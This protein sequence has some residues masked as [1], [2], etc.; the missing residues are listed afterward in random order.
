MKRL[1]LGFCVVALTFVAGCN[2]NTSIGGPLPLSTVP[3]TANGGGSPSPK[4]S[5]QITEYATTDTLLGG[6]TIASDGNIYASATTGLDIFSPATGTIHQ[7][8]AVRP[9]TWPVIPNASPTGAVTSFP[10]TVTALGSQ[11]PTATPSMQAAV[12]TQSSNAATPFIATYAIVTKTFTE[13]YGAPGDLFEDVTQTADGSTWVTADRPT[14]N[15]FTG[16]IFTTKANCSPPTVADAIGKITLGAD[17]FIWFASDPPLNSNTPSLIFRLD[18]SSGALVNTF[19]LPANSIVAD[20][21]PGPDGALWFADRGLNKIGRLANDGTMT[22]FAV[23]TANSGLF[24]ITTGCDGALWFTERGANQ[25]GRLTTTGTFTEYP[26]PT[27]N[28]GL[29]EIA[30]CLNNAMYFTETHAIGKVVK[31]P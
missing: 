29:G 28:A 8:V 11:S 14:S 1:A 24:G 5:V 13:V 4:S 31:T 9:Q 26:V 20:M 30:G 23:P 17:N 12:T 22:F 25:V 10:G 16:F 15:G 2:N 19:T 3:P 18:P 6:L 27:A 7:S 21:T